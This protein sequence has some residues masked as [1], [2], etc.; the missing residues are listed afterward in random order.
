MIEEILPGLYKLILPLSGVFPVGINSYIVKSGERSLIIDVGWNRQPCMDSMMTGLKELK[1]NFA[2]TDFFI[3]HFHPDHLNLIE[4]LATDDSVVYFNRPE[5]EWMRS[6]F[7]WEDLVALGHRNGFPDDEARAA[8]RQHPGYGHPLGRNLPFKSV[9]EDTLITMGNFTFQCIETPGHA[10]RHM[11]LYEPHEKVFLSGDLILKDLIT[12]IQSWWD[13][14]NPMEEYLASLDKVNGLDIARVLPGHGEV[15]NHCRQR[16][17]EL[18]LHHQSRLDEIF[19]ILRKG[20]MTAFQVASQMSW[21][22]GQKSIPWESLPLLFRW[23]TVGESIAYLRCLEERGM[24]S[25]E[26]GGEKII[27]HS[28]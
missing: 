27:Y 6:G 11:C 19:S 4:N 8:I 9:S 24:I 21:D 18:K 7:Q 14:D 12:S 20:G 5:D 22:N 23:F 1:V 28:S 15:F 3:T 17:K 2:K 13:E 10:K 16:I 26:T 25:R